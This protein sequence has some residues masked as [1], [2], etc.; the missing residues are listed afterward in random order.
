MGIKHTLHSQETTMFM[1]KSTHRSIV[2][3]MRKYAGQRIAD[4]RFEIGSLRADCIVLED[5]LDQAHA[6]IQ[7]LQGTNDTLGTENI[8]L[9]EQLDERQVPAVRGSRGRFVK[10]KG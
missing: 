1:L 10:R 9:R 7:M 4:H 5:N 6:E 3:A 2:D 8:V